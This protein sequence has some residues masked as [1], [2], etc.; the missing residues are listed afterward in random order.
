[1][2]LSSIHRGSRQQAGTALDVECESLP[3]SHT[4]RSVQLAG[5][6]TLRSDR[7]HTNVSSSHTNHQ[8]IILTAWATQTYARSG[9]MALLLWFILLLQP[10]ILL[11][12]L[13]RH[14]P[15]LWCCASKPPNKSFS[16]KIQQSPHWGVL[17]LLLLLL[18]LLPPIPCLFTH[19]QNAPLHRCAYATSLTALE[20]FEL[21]PFSFLSL[22]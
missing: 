21:L 2:F 6:A 10:L 13:L 16:V 19:I 11:E 12:L 7:D 20:A 8:K 3:A 4:R 22:L 9:S 15:V 17:L 1:M 14:L 18:L 5:W